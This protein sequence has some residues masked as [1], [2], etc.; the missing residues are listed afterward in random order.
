MSSRMLWQDRWSKQAAAEEATGLLQGNNHQESAEYDIAM[1]SAPAAQLHND[2]KVSVAVV[3][4]RKW[5]LC[6]DLKTVF[7]TL[8]SV[9]IYAHANY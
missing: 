7:F 5:T 2:L 8:L 4:I 9:F 3:I 1:H 6:W